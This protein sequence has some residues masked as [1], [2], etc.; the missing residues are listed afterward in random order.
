MK[1]KLLSSVYLVTL[2]IAFLCSLA[3]LQ[4]NTAK[5]KF[6]VLSNELIKSAF[7][8]DSLSLHFAFTNPSEFGI[9][10]SIIRFPCYDRENYVSEKEE[11]EKTL[12]SLS[13]IDRNKLSSEAR[14]TYDI[15]YHYLTEKE[16]GTD[17]PYFE[18]P[19][20]PTSGIHISLPVLLAEY[21]MESEKDVI[22]YLTLLKQIP[23]Y[24][25]SLASF[26]TDKAAQ[27]LF[28]SG[29]DVNLVISQ[30]RFLASEK[31]SQLY[32]ACF[33]G[34]LK[35]VYSIGSDDFSYYQTRQQQIFNTYVAPAYQKLSDS[36]SLLEI[37]GKEQKGLCQ[38]PNGSK[39]YEYHLQ[40]VIGT[41]K[42]CEE[43]SILLKER[44]SSLYKE[45]CTLKK[46]YDQIHAPDDKSSMTI[47]KAPDI[48]DYLPALSKEFKELFPSLDQTQSVVIKEIP[49]NLLD[50]TAPA[51]Y[52]LPRIQTCL[53][54]HT[55]QI[56]NVIYYAKDA[57]QQ[58]VSL[59]TTLAHEGFPGHMYQNIYFISKHGV[60]EDNLLRYRLDFPGYQEGWAMYV[61]LLSYEN[62]S[63]FTGLDETYCK[64]LRLSRELQICMLCYLD[65]EI[66]ANGAVL[67]DIT[68]QLTGIGIKDPNTIYETYS[69]L[70]NE[71]G[72]YLK[73]YM[74]YLELLSCKQLYKERC[75]KQ[76][77]PYCD[78]DFHTFFLS[79]GPDSF[80][81]IKNV[82]SQ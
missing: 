82:I 53:P 66:H 76:N 34:Q 13:A 69:Y 17:F 68:P 32:A 6:R 49:Q 3:Y 80:V 5:N 39:Y 73:Y 15:L 78:L 58:P 4:K 8:Q 20:S 25:A 28:M 62:A 74:G 43:I 19:L 51:Y 1:K 61:E 36:L 10:D 42:T 44:Y 7:E 79:H 35:N 71:P 72:T 60:N 70:I 33:A 11:I 14:E 56:Q 75:Q 40:N 18:E 22:S 81:R 57:C 24:F 59:Y 52:F 63:A 46:S 9:D 50:Y 77:I 29:E 16:K 26:E 48:K 41:D 37:P 23:T 30:C 45:Y 64:L 54:G 27:G 31:G 12:T 55:N 2:L 21:S 67:K 38:Y 47:M 65:I